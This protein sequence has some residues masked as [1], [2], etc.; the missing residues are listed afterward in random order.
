LKVFDVIRPKPSTPPRQQAQAE[1]PPAEKL[2]DNPPPQVAAASHPAADASR[3]IEITLTIPRLPKLSD[4]PRGLG[5]LLWSNRRITGAVG[6]ALVAVVAFYIVMH[7]SAP[8]A[9]IHGGATRPPQLIKGTPDYATVLPAGKTI[10]DYGGWTRISPPNRDPV[11]AYVDKVSNVQINVSEQPL[12]AGF[13]AN[14]AAQTAQLAQSFNATDKF[15]VGNAPVY[16]ATS[17]DGEQSAILS[18]DKLLILIKSNSPLTN[19]QWAAY[20]NTLH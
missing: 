18:K 12:P 20:I 6:I 3:H 16:I 9:P 4:V 8:V 2:A 15:T 1:T 7:Q 13:T 5:R 19:N 10:A 11:Y 14:P 17:S